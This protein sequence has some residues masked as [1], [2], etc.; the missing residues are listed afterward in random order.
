MWVGVCGELHPR[1]DTEA[2][3]NVEECLLNK[4][5]MA[6]FFSSLPI[7]FAFTS[8]AA[9]L[10][11]FDISPL[12]SAALQIPLSHLHSLKAHFH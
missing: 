3:K 10:A 8:L 6:F 1:A 12:C 9:T 5:R 11:M 2:G 4:V 7:P